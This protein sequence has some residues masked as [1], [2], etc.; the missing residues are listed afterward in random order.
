[1]IFLF[2]YT[3]KQQTEERLQLIARNAAETIGLDE[4]QKNVRQQIID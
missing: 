4:T 2:L 1:M 3:I